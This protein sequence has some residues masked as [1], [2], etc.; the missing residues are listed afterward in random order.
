MCYFIRDHSPDVVV[1]DILFH[2]NASIADSVG[3]PCVTFHVIGAFPM[4]ALFSLIGAGATD[5]V[6][7]LPEYMGPDIQIPVTE[8]P[9]EVRSRRRPEDVRAEGAKLS[10]AHSSCF[11]LVV[12]TFFDLE[13]RYCDMYVRHGYA[14]RAY[15]VGPL[16]LP[17]PS[18]LAA[19][20]A[21][22]RCIDWL[23]R[24]PARSVV[25]LCFGS[26]THIPELQLHELALGLEASG[27]PGSRSCGWSGRRHGRRRRGGKS[28]SGT[29]ECSSRGGPHRR[30]SLRTR[31]WGCS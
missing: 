3:V 9:E 4:L 19:G 20:E 27:S 1:S 31:L 24:K 25:Y 16:S 2:W 7:T 21:G 18:Q 10:S 28:A 26:L 23:D 14:K 8:L 30:R 5:G 29:G 22:S 17:P 11:G 15:F 12:N 6:L 13:D